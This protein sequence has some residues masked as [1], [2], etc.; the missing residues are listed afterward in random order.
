MPAKS[1]GGAKANCLIRSKKKSPPKN[2]GHHEDLDP[3]LAAT[4]GQKN[5]IDAMPL[6]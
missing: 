1:S 2:R 3:L 4:A 5:L 6:P